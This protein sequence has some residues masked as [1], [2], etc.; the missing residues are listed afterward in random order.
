[1]VLERFGRIAIVGV[2]LIGG[3]IGKALRAR[4]LA[5]RIVGVG[6][7]AGRLAQAQRAG[8]IDEA[9]TELAEAVAETDVAVICTPVDRIAQDIRSVATAGADNLLVT[10]AG[11][12]KHAI[13]EAVESH[14]RARAAYVGAHPIAGSEQQG[15]AFATADLF[16]GRPCVVT[17]TKHTPADRLRRAVE[18]WRSLGCQV[19]ELE[20]L[21]H[22]QALAYTSHLPHAVA[23]ALAAAVPAAWRPLA[24][25]AFR[26]GTR[27][28]AADAELWAAIFLANRR[29]LL[30]AVSEFQRQLR[31]F[32]LALAGSD[33]DAILGWWTQA[34]SRCHDVATD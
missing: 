10:D 13:V 34:Q 33:R 22:D 18:F 25:G 27:V 7:D 3:S 17:P 11:S 26:D 5:E 32:G 16:E 19:I 4:G 12:T 1:M 28:A 8:A 15:V 23:A 31:E 6:R 30:E 20:P 9:T 21:A 29:P 2:G 24:G 14:S